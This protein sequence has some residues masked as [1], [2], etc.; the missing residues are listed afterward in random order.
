M[1]HFVT[2]ELDRIKL[3]KDH[4]VDIK[5]RMSY[6][7]QQRLVSHYIKLTGTTGAVDIDM[8]AGAVE[9]LVINIKAWSLV[10]AG[11]NE[12]SLSRDAIEQ[13]DPAVAERI[14]AEI[15][16]RNPAPKA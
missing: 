4:W 9:L 15:N 16:K 6:G 13:L 7:D 1:S 2:D 8:A 14:A 11:D 5:R 12:V 3:D 10:N